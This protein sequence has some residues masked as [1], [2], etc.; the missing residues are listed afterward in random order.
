[1]DD[2]SVRKRRPNE[3]VWNMAGLDGAERGVKKRSIP[4]EP[5]SDHHPP[6][7]CLAN[8]EPVTISHTVD[9]A[10]TAPIKSLLEA[11]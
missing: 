5:G 10:A 4:S 6:R 8:A 11:K 2:V 7:Q 3:T 1:M 9:D